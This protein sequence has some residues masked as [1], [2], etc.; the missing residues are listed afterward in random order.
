[1]NSTCLAD[2]CP[3]LNWPVKFQR[4]KFIWLICWLI[5]RFCCVKLKSYAIT[6]IP[7]D[8]TQRCRK[9]HSAFSF[10]GMFCQSYLFLNTCN[11]ST[12]IT[13]CWTKYIT[14]SACTFSKAEPFQSYISMI[15]LQLFCG[16]PFPL[17]ASF[18]RYF[19]KL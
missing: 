6:F 11:D 16:I 18:H 3:Y 1:M 13:R 19:V 15:N 10:K 4:V 9:A 5:F 12:T 7:R 17:P 2:L 14:M 8:L